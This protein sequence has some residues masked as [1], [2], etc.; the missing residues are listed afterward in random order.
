[1]QNNDWHDAGNHAFSAQLREAGA[2][3]PGLMLIFNPEAQSMPFTVVNGPWQLALDSSGELSSPRA[4]PVGTPLVVPARA[5]LV[6]RRTS[7]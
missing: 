1:M 3:R 7:S 6:L 5:L 4:V 2:A